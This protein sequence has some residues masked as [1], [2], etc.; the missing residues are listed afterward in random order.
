MAINGHKR[1]RW[2]ENLMFCLQFSTT[3]NSK[4]PN[5]GETNGILGYILDL[6][7]YFFYLRHFLKY[8]Q[9]SKCIQV[10]RSNFAPITKITCSFFK[11]KSITTRTDDV[12]VY[13]IVFL[14]NNIAILLLC[15]VCHMLFKTMYLTY[16]RIIC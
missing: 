7:D 8:R 5:V 1:Q 16:Q 3:L 12:S 11:K 6:F 14:V 2:L 13:T 15:I 9:I 10:V 4:S